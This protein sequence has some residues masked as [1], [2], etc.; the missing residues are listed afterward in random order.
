VGE[1]RKGRT[2]GFDESPRIYWTGASG[3]RRRSKDE[4]PRRM[5]EKREEALIF[6]MSIHDTQILSSKRIESTQ[7]SLAPR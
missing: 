7:G 6:Y 2:I 5:R 3:A 1:E 4:S